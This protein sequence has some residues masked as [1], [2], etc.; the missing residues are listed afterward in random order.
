MEQKRVLTSRRS[1]SMKT[2]LILV[3]WEHGCKGPLHPGDEQKDSLWQS[4][5]PGKEQGQPNNWALLSN[6]QFSFLHEKPG[7]LT[8][9]TEPLRGWLS[10]Q[11]LIHY[12]LSHE[13]V[14][15]RTAGSH[16]SCRTFPIN[17]SGPHP[18]NSSLHSCGNMAH[19]VLS[20]T[21]GMDN[22]LTRGSLE[23]QPL[24]MPASTLG[25]LFNREGYAHPL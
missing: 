13:D 20:N 5:I 15:S 24:L 11:Q 4:H 8:H 22:P 19:P 25:I 1:P 3:L 18:I 23:G 2:F 21:Q 14:V 16:T 10:Y 9:P 7:A 6:L 17:A 12:L